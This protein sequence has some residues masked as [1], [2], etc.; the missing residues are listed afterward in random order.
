MGDKAK[1]ICKICG[2]ELQETARFCTFCGNKIEKVE[3]TLTTKVEKKSG[4][5]KRMIGFL[6]LLFV[7]VAVVSAV[8]GIFF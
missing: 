1:M 5:N 3:L 2:K 8:I 7:V 4:P 6:A